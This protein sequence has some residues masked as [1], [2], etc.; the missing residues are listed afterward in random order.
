MEED[1]DEADLKKMKIIALLEATATM[2]V[3]GRPVLNL[4]EKSSITLLVEICTWFCLYIL[5]KSVESLNPPDWLNIKILFYTPANNA[6]KEKVSDSEKNP[7]EKGNAAAAK[8]A[9]EYVS[10]SFQG[11]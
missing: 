9:A 3:E 11:T 2:G 7:S 8:A 5:D 6:H 4:P 10:L 1:R